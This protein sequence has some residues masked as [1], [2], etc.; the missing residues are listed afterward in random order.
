MGFVDLSPTKMSQKLD[1]CEFH[2]SHMKNMCEIT[3]I[4]ET[5]LENDLKI[6]SKQTENLKISK[7]K[8]FEKNEKR[9]REKKVVKR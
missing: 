6:K 5:N 2:N 8:T 3:N 7:Q 4:H 1:F 9:M